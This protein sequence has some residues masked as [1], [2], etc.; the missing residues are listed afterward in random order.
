MA[1][2]QS[3]AALPTP[4]S[5][6]SD[7]QSLQALKARNADGTRKRPSDRLDARSE[8][9]SVSTRG[10]SLPSLRRE[11]ERRGRCGRSKAPAS[12]PPQD[13]KLSISCLLAAIRFPHCCY[14]LVFAAISNLLAAISCYVLSISSPHCCY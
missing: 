12:K 3:Y 1:L 10:R 7:T 8:E 13:V 5:E 11:V 2:Q 9:D 6:S 4:E 14:E